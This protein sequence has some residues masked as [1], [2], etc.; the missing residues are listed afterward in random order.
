MGS[1]AFALKESFAE[2]DFH[3][4]VLARHD[5]TSINVGEELEKGKGYIIVDDP[6][7][8]ALLD[9][10]EPLKRAVLTDARKARSSKTESSKKKEE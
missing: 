7:D 4:G 6:H 8:E 10:Y 3:A 1:A 5:G 9:Q 2:R